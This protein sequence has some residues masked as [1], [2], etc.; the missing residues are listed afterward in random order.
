MV[1]IE[2]LGGRRFAAF[3]SNDAVFLLVED[4]SK[5]SNRHP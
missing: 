2:G 5:R 1:I 3:V 4:T